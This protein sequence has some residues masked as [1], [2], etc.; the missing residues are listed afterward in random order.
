[1][2]CAT[3]C[4]DPNFLKSQSLQ[5][6]HND[7]DGVWYYR[8]LVCLLNRLFRRR[9]KKTS[10]LR[11]TSLW[12]GNHRWLVDSPHKGPV[13]RKMFPFDDVIMCLPILSMKLAV[14]TEGDNKVW[15]LL[16]APISKWITYKCFIWICPLNGWYIREI[17]FQFKPHTKRD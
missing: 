11:V 2:A 17:V 7:C 3:L 15:N 5:W 10:K 6:R 8:R 12:E 4:S 16:G 1:M 14:N 13:T 9:S